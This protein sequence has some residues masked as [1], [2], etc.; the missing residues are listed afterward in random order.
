MFGKLKDRLR[1][2]LST[3]SQKAE[4]EV[5]PEPEKIR[6][7]EK[8]EIVKE[9]PVEKPKEKP[10]EGVKITYF[11]HGTTTDNEQ[12]KS[13]GWAPGQL[14]E[15]G[16]KQSVELKEQ[17]KDK[18]FDIIISSDLK[19]AVDSTKL[20]FGDSG[21]K[22]FKDKRLREV[23][24]GDLTQ[25]PE[26]QVN[27]S[28]HIDQ[29]FPNGESLKDVEKRIASFLNNLLEK[30]EGKHVALVAH[31]APQLALDVLLKGKNWEQAIKDD[32]RHKKAW[33]PGWEYELKEKVEIPEIK[34]VEEKKPEPALEPEVKEKPK[35]EIK[36][37]PKVGEKEESLP[38]IKEE[39]QPK[40]KEEKPIEKEKKSFFKKAREYISTKKI[41]ASKF[42]ELFWDLEMA[43]LENNVS[44]EVIEKI[45]NDLK[46]ELVDKPLPRN[47]SQKIE[48]TLKN[49][50]QEVLDIEKI[51]LLE[52]T[53][54]KKPFVIAFF[55]VNGSGKTTSIAKIAHLLKKQGLKS[56]LA[57][58]DTFRAA[59]IHQLEEHANNLNLKIIKHDYGAD[60]AAVAFDALKYAEKNNLDAVLIDTAGR[61]HSDVNLMDELKKIV[62]VVNPDLKVFVGESITGNDCVEQAS[63]FNEHIGIDGIVLTKADVDEKGGA[64]ISVSFIT[65]KPILFIG[66]GQ[67]YEDLV[68]FN[69]DLVLENLGL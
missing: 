38:E 29:P 20:T 60:A 47:I 65:K 13:T 40:P 35:S 14:S 52:K 10:I 56:V 17:V 41:S 32:W 30:F 37:E 67:N 44:V 51:D 57:A 49:S 39:P 66:T 25:A 5:A 54:Q 11:V 23:D 48:E 22:I 64:A 3:F 61:L 45:K 24:Y 46:E 4:E 2:T 53:K 19:R 9:K 69:P 7:E 42:D 8:E 59:A 6:E 63:R 36:K 62:R 43:L 21:I 15:L 16:K 33:Q 68:K 28:E 1:K 34:P 55:G 50:L 26:T 27:Y 18:K 12:G 31:K 58:S